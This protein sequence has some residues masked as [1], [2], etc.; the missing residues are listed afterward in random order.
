[1]KKPALFM[2]ATFLLLSTSTIEA[3]RHVKTEELPH[4]AKTFL[5]VYFSESTIDKVIQKSHTSDYEVKTHDG[6]EFDFDRTGRWKSVDCNLERVPSLLIPKQILN[7]V[8]KR[9][10][11]E[12]IIV[13]ISRI[14]KGYHV[15]LSNGVEVAFNKRFK[16]VPI[17]H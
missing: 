6:K 8:A 2:I 17:K 4:D 10:G 11:P 3:D 12:T 16:I 15:E 14:K 7:E 13:W 1:M 9:Y 5:N